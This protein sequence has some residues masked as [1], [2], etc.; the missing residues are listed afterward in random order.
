LFFAG[1][2]YSAYLYRKNILSLF[3]AENTSGFLA[4]NADRWMKL[5]FLASIFVGFSAAYIP[6]GAKLSLG[7]GRAAAL[8]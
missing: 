3:S 1:N 8:P 6:A 7:Q 2:T 4:T 5:C